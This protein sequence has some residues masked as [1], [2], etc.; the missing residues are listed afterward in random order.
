MAAIIDPVDGAVPHERQQDDRADSGVEEQTPLNE[1]TERA[2]RD[3]QS[4]HRE[5]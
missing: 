4:G 5:K 1:R 2:E 3:G